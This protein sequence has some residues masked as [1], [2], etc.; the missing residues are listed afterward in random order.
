MRN[1]KVNFITT[2][3]MM[4]VRWC[5]QNNVNIKSYY[6]WLRRIR[7]LACEIMLYFY[8]NVYYTTIILYPQ[9]R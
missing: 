2:S 5:E 1:G 6:Y 8:I 9:I 4:V 7:S 3:G